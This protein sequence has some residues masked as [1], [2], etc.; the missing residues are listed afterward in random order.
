MNF[1]DLNLIEPIAKAIQEQGYTN[2]TPIQERSIPEILKG[3]DFLGC[4]QTG[5]GKTAAFAIPILQ[6]LSKSKTKNNHIKALIL[7]PTRELAIQ[8]EENINAY[9]K[10]LPLKQLVIFGGVKQGNQEAALRR[11]ID[12]L[13]ATPG[14]LLDFIAQ[15]IISLKNIEIFVLDEADRML[16]MG[17]VHDVKRVIKLLPQRR[18][19]LFFSATMPS[20]IQKLADSILNNPVKVEVTP[21]S[22][23]A[24]TIK[25]SVYFVDKE[26]K[27]DLL[28]HILENDIS[29]SVLVFSRTKHGADKIARKLQKDNISAEAIHGNKS[30]NARQNALNNFKSGKTRILVATDI[31]A[32]GIDID[33]LKYV[34]NFE[35]SDVSET[36]VHRI[37][38]TGRAGAE[39]SSISFVDSLDLLNLRNTEK[40]IGKKIPVIKEHPFHTDNLVAQKR[41]SN[42]KPS[43]GG[44]D[45]RPPRSPKP[46]NNNNKPAAGSTPTGFKKPKNK[47]FT[48]KK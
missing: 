46:Q 33:E 43:S 1:T 4:A 42:N 3:S 23:T 20:E 48:R 6:N 14:R 34:I 15:G 31:A 11:G 8:I 26:N 19:T 47:N 35:L 28:S 10:Y 30:Q 41:D 7:T 22:S 27:L 16:D 9:G 5:T 21:V 45:R 12:I 25:Q 32:R 13:V 24:E 38:R 36:Y 18:Q 29:D 40:L 37:G 44:G 39:G 17:F 2:P